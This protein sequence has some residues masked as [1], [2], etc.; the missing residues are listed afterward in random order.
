MKK[1]ACF[2]AMVACVACGYDVCDVS[3]EDQ[4]GGLSG[5]LSVVLEYDTVTSKAS[6]D[7]LE[8]L[9]DENKINSVS[10]LVFDKQTEK[11]NASKVVYNVTDPCVFSI[12]AGEKAVYAVANAPDLSNILTVSQLKAVINDLSDTDY[13]SKG[14]VMIGSAVCQVRLGETAE[15]VITLKRMVARVVVRQMKNSVASQYGEIRVDCV[16]LANANKIQTLGGIPS[17]PVNVGGYADAAKTSAIGKNGVTGDCPIYMY[18]EAGA[19]I[20]QGKTSANLYHMYCHPT[21]SEAKTCLYALL[22]IAGN[23]YYYRVPLLN[24]LQAN[25]TYSV[26]IE[27]VN[28]GAPTPPEGD[29]Q[30]GEIKAVVNV[31]GWDLGDSYTIEF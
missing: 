12:T 9:D 25:K 13:K 30:K 21:T 18:R 20:G 5:E 2:F 15:P 17:V 23:Q 27:F 1:I 11:L 31:S 3:G 6:D 7:Y 16:Y 10:I 19:V 8:T 14:F 26:D 28:L 22:T 4:A 24:G 29:L